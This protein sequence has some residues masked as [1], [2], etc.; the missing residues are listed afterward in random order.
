M[1]LRGLSEAAARFTEVFMSEF[2]TK[3][4]EVG[5][6]DVRPFYGSNLFKSHGMRINLD[7]KLIIK[8]YY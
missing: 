7:K 3:A 6:F 1:Q 4:K 8:T 5:V 2:E